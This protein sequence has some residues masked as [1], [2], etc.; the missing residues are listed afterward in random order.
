MHQLNSTVLVFLILMSAFAGAG[1][2]SVLQDGD[3]I[4]IESNDTTYL[5]YK[6][7]DLQ[8]NN[9]QMSETISN[10]ENIIKEQNDEITYL[11][12]NLAVANISLE[13][14]QLELVE[15]RNLLSEWVSFALNNYFGNLELTDAAMQQCLDHG[16]TL[17]FSD[18]RYR[19]L[20]T[21]LINLDFWG[22]NLSFANLENANLDY[23]VF[24][25]SDLSYANLRS[26]NLRG[27]NFDSADLSYANLAGSQFIF[28]DLHA[29]N[30][31]GAN[32]EFAYFFGVDLSQAYLH[33]ANLSGAVY[34]STTCPDGTNSEDNGGT[35]ENNL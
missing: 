35:C 20:G 11:E 8:E 1:V 26:A 12:D 24:Q 25:N 18:L 14:L 5:E 30:L 22:S 28:T 6:I 33:E 27:T 15:C 9:S 2:T 21:D 7:T 3:T 34:E 32:L 19:N 13:S 31:E 4:N 10:L 23:T 29:A 17:R 16:I